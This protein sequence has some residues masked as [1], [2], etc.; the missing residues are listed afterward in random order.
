MALAV[1]MIASAQGV[2]VGCYIACLGFAEPGRRHRRQRVDGGRV[3]EPG[4]EVAGRVRHHA[5]DVDAAC[6]MLERRSDQ[7]FCRRN[8]GDDVTG[9]AAILSERLLATIRIAAGESHEL[10]CGIGLSR[11]K[12]T[13]AV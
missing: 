10:P 1:A 13:L 9:R 12:Q 5:A 7:P 8:P 3:H 2:E 11:P 4:H 6:E